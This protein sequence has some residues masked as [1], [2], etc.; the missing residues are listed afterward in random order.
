MSRRPGASELA[1]APEARERGARRRSGSHS[2]LGGAT[3][4][5][6]GCARAWGALTWPPFL[7]QPD[8][9]PSLIRCFIAAAGQRPGRAALGWRNA[10]AGPQS[11]VRRRRPG[12]CAGWAP[13]A[14]RSSAASQ[15]PRRRRLSRSRQIRDPRLHGAALPAEPQAQPSITVAAPRG[16]RGAEPPNRRAPFSIRRPRD[17]RREGVRP[18]VGPAGQGLPSIVSRGPEGGVKSAPGGRCGCPR[19]SADRDRL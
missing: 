12:F 15:A 7:I 16:R 10:P 5:R 2:R 1:A 8:E 13:Q 14:C 18:G 11:S 4:G 9:S 3:T 6:C 19:P 17:A